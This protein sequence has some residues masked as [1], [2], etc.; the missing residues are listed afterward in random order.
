MNLQEIASKMKE[1]VNEKIGVFTMQAKADGF[2]KAD[3]IREVLLKIIRVSEKDA[4]DIERILSL[5]INNLQQDF[6]EIELADIATRFEGVITFWNDEHVASHNLVDMDS[7][8]SQY[9]INT[10]SQTED[11]SQRDRKIIKSF[12]DELDKKLQDELGYGLEEMLGKSMY[13]FSNEFGISGVDTIDDIVEY[14]YQVPEIVRATSDFCLLT[15]QS[16]DS[17]RGQFDQNKLFKISRIQAKQ[18]T[19]LQRSEQ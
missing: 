8:M 13:P 16:V 7:F 17:I 6:T 1:T 15:R 2:A 5:L 12:L 19:S 9:A 11:I 10:D 3:V 14:L 4:N 18:E